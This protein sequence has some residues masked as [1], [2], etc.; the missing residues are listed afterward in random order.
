[1]PTVL[2][3]LET[4]YLPTSAPIDVTSMLLCHSINTLMRLC[5]SG[6][7]FS[8]R[9]PSQI[10]DL[11]SERPFHSPLMYLGVELETLDLTN[12][13]VVAR[14]F[15]L[16][17]ELVIITAKSVTVVS[18]LTSPY[19]YGANVLS[20]SYHLHRASEWIHSYSHRQI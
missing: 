18:S 14:R 20:Y 13:A 15:P 10:F 3:N 2:S 16:L 9:Q 1:M 7:Y 6:H 19:S 5:F 8:S 12:L 4:L 17:Y 11:F